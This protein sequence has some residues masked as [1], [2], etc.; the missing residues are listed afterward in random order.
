MKFKKLL[1]TAMAAALA[2]SAFAGCGAQAEESTETAQTAESTGEYADTITL[3]W[4]P[5]ESA[6]DYDV[7]RS[8]YARLIEEATGKK[9]EQKLTTDYAIAIESLA[10]GTAQICFMGAQGYIEAKNA[11]DAIEPLFVNSGASGTLMMQNTTASWQLTKGTKENMQTVTATAST[12]S[13]A[14]ACLLFPIAPHPV[15]KYPQTPLFLTSQI[16]I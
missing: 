9:V 14:N 15:S 5:N 1:T 8:E 3:V 7:A 16:R 13:Q 12:I 2:V 11:N 6:E 4:Y 10:N